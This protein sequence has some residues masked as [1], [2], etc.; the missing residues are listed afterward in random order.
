MAFSDSTRASIDSRSKVLQLGKDL[1][2]YGIADLMR[3]PKRAAAYWR[4]IASAGIVE[5]L[6]RTDDS[7][8]IPVCQ[9]ESLLPDCNAI[10]VTLADYRYENGDMPLHELV[11]LCRTVRHRRP[12]KIFEIATFLGGTTLQLAANTG[13]D[14]V[15]YTLD[16]PPPGHPDYVRPK[17]IDADLDV[18]PSEPG[19]RFRNSPHS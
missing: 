7:S 13:G 4:R 14:A 18:Y 19:V 16:L 17:V 3:S 10:P 8:P 1:L 9:V 12:K 5:P 6:A 15:I 11:T 2:Q